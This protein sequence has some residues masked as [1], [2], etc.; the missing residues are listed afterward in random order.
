MKPKTSVMS[1]RRTQSIIAAIFSIAIACSG[2]QRVAVT[3]PTKPAESVPHSSPQPIDAAPPLT[4]D[5]ALAELRT[6]NFGASADVIERRTAQ[7]ERKMQLSSDEALVAATSL[8]ELADRESFRMLVT[9]MP[10]STVELAR[11]VRERGVSVEEADAIAHYLARVASTL[12]FERLH[13]FDENHSHV[14]GRE[15]HEIDYSGENMTWQGQRD[16]WTPR[17]VQSFERAAYIHAY[18]VGAERLPHWKR[19]YRPRGRMADVTPPS[20]D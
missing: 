14:T 9:V 12:A 2:E 5:G 11:A 8:L 3:E 4:L 6:G 7:R 10:R 20:A 13:V 16:Y 17:G 19:A 1:A 15:W 18:F